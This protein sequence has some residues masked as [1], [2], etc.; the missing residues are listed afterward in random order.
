M[1][2]VSFPSS[3]GMDPATAVLAK[4]LKTQEDNKKEVESFFF[5]G[6]KRCRAVYNPVKAASLPSSVGIV[7]PN[8]L[9][10]RSLS[11]IKKK[12][13]NQ[14]EDKIEQKARTEKKEFYRYWM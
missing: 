5:H 14:K 4:A 10:P 9:N 3:V 7:P 8:K 2:E 11:E 6:G 1:R 12:D 13:Q